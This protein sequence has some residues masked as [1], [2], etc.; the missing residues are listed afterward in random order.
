MAKTHIVNFSDVFPS[1]Y[2]SV[3]EEYQ[4]GENSYREFFGRVPF[5]QLAINL[6]SNDRMRMNNEVEGIWQRAVVTYFKVI[7]QE[8]AWRNNGN[9]RKTHNSRSQIE[10]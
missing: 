8:F 1:W 4:D 6:K 2:Y 9:H 10:I 3:T 5:L 7:I